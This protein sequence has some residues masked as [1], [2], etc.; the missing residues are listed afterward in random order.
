MRVAVT[1]STFAEYDEEPLRLLRAGGMDIV[2]NPHRRTLAESEAADILR[3]CSGVVAG[4][5][6]LTAAVM[7][8]APGLKVISRCGSGLDNVDA[9]AARARGI[10]ICSTPFAPVEAVAELTLALALDLSRRI[11]L[12]DREVR[13]GTWKKRM[14]SLLAGKQVG[15][16]GFGR[17]GR[18][19][20]SLFTLMGCET[21]FCD[22]GVAGDGSCRRMEG[23]DLLAWADII[24]L[25]CPPRADGRPLLDAAG[26]GRMKDGA[27]LINAA[28]GGLVDES[29]L[30]DA[31]Q[32][33]KAAGAA[34]DVFTREPYPP[35]GPL[36]SLPGVILTPHIG[37][38][39][40][41]TRA[42]METESVRNLLAV[43]HGKNC[44][45]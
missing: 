28:R 15:I 34:L 3:G 30:A 1:T 33:G 25:H 12:M 11:T 27:L 41:E 6:P 40:A 26:L 45:K 8:A 43:L 32:S 42:A 36:A 29:A 38:Y 4:T 16:F 17:I 14:G 22:P 19:V 9:A 24:T 35:S 37:A 39:A 18:K 44:G 21:A 20:A 2:F 23:D 31:L 10:Q 13:A 5:E 7:D